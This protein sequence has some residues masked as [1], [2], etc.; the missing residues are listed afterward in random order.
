[1][2][3]NKIR[4]K[5]CGFIFGEGLY[6]QCPACGVPSKMFEPFEDKLPDERRKWLDK[7]FH[8]IIVHAPQGLGFLT[9]PLVILYIIVAANVGSALEQTLYSALSVMAILLPL[10]VFAG[11]ISGMIDGRVRYK[12]ISSIILRRK[13]LLGVAFLLTSGFMPVVIFQ[14]GFAANTA[15]QIVF[16]ALNLAAFGCSVILGKYGASLNLGE[17]PGPYPK[18][19]KPAKP[20]AGAQA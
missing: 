6:D 14:A 17:M 2:K 11:W 1:M 10:T 9:I 3:R 8:G 20:T 18:K 13:I 5:A 19:K 16:L 7:H 12:T 15:L 4:C